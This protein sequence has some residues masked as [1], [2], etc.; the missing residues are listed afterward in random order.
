MR[1]FFILTLMIINSYSFAV[2]SHL[3]KPQLSVSECN[4]IAADIN[5]ITPFQVNKENILTNVFCTSEGGTQITYYYEVTFK[6][7]NKDEG[8]RKIINKW[9]TDP[10]TNALLTLVANVKFQYNDS[11]GKRINDIVINDSMCK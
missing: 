5:K 1:L 2:V 9:C 10:D 8:K 3:T 11:N 6:T 4:E 7:L